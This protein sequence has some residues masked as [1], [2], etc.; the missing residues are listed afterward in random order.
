MRGQS[1]LLL[2]PSDLRG[3]RM[4]ARALK[5]GNTVGLLPDQV[6]SQGDGVWVPFFKRPA[7]TMTLPARLALSNHARVVLFFC[8]RLPKASYRVHYMPLAES[9]SGPLPDGTPRQIFGAPSLPGKATAIVG[10]RRAG[11]TT[12]LHQLRR[13]RMAQ[14][15]ARVSFSQS[16]A[17]DQLRATSQKRLELIK[18]NDKWV[19]RKESVG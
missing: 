17:A 10:M 6:P 9:L 19:I 12:Y 8:E 1:G 2:A 11:K 15:V 7:Y 4:L 14:G 16:Y 5:Q 18:Q 13:E 3:V